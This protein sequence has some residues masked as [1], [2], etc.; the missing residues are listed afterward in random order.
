MKSTILIIQLLVAI[1]LICLIL[2]QTSKGGLRTEIGGADF[3]RTKRGAEKVV[4]TATIICA[5]LFFL[6][7]II[8][9]FFIL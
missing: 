5:V 1:T 8:N 2:L 7:T 6:V 9:V 4:F 3:Y